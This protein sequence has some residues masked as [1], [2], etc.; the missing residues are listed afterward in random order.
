MSFVY[1]PVMEKKFE[2]F[3]NVYTWCENEQKNLVRI[4][5]QGCL[6]NGAQF[7]DDECFGDEYTAFRFNQSGL[8]SLCS[9]FGITIDTLELLERQNLVTEVLNDLL[10]QQPIQ[11]KLQ[12]RELIVDESKN[13]I[14]GIVSNSYVGYS[15][16]QLLQNVEKLIKPR[17]ADF[18]FK[19]AYS[20]NSQM[21]L[22]FT[23]EKQV[24]VIKSHDGDFTDKT[25]L[26]FQLKNSMVGNSSI[27]I[28]FYLYRLVCANGLI[29]PAG[30]SV[31][32]IFHSGKQEN[33]FARL[34]RVFKELT[35]RIGE[36]EKMIEDLGKL[37]F[38]PDLL[39]KTN[40][41]EM[42]FTIIPGSKSQILDKYKIPNAF[43]EGNKAENKIHREAKIINYIPD[44]FGGEFSKQVFDSPWRNNASMFDFINIFTEH[45]KTLS[46]GKK[47]ES[48]EKTGILADW[49]AKNKRKFQHPFHWQKDG[50]DANERELKI[51]D[52]S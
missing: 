26:G 22:R 5:I 32:R 6:E 28:N 30:S 27:N 17:E 48:E 1:E 20:V 47:I 37:E 39:A 35:S 13:T 51:C 45:A 41:S 44:L 38:S 21:S 23:M 49:I 19:E 40:C 12:S 15:N 11:K 24:G 14:M 43:R 8:R 16:L 52:E 42:I 18:T 4:P 31:N 34:E 3:D 36:A 7:I 29:A 50:E 2:S 10:A 9:Y 46:P 33:L 25:K